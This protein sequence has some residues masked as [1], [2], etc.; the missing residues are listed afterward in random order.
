MLRRMRASRR[1]FQEEEGVG[2]DSKISSVPQH[3][4]RRYQKRRLNR[5]TYP[6]GSSVAAA[7]RRRP[8][9]GG[10]K[11]QRENSSSP[12]SYPSASPVGTSGDEMTITDSPTSQ[13]TYP[14]DD[15]LSSTHDWDEEEFPTVS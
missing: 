12:P 3:P 1:Y 13:Q 14:D 10:Q 6:T 15:E 8:R 4:H 7:V 5:E 11:D 9:G 2:G